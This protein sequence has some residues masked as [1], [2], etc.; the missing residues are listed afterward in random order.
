M[1]AKYKY[2][3]GTFDAKTGARQYAT[4]S[5]TTA[6]IPTSPADAEAF[7]GYVPVVFPAD[8]AGFPGFAAEVKYPFGE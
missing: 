6:I 3:K 2:F 8:A 7:T 4:Y 5:R 1:T